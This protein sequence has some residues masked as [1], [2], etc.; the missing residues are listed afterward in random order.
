MLD[1]SNDTGVLKIFPVAVR[2]FDINHQRIM[3][4][5]FHMNL[6][7]ERDASTTAEMFSIVDKLFIKY[8]ISWDFVTALDVASVGEYNSFKSRALV[9]NGNIFIGGSP[10]Y[11]LHNAACK[12]GAAFA[13][14]TGFGI[15]DHC[16]NLF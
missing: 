13:T 1:G 7:K 3:T 5:C 8:G 11:I 4:K 2:I 6:M 15:E 16:V 9:K 12:S 14:V 10:C